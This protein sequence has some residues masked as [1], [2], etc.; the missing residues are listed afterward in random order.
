MACWSSHSIINLGLGT[1][2]RYHKLISS[3]S[4][5]L[6]N[7]WT[8]SSLGYTNSDLLPTLLLSLQLIIA[9][10]IELNDDHYVID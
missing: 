4:L 7:F 6:I 5:L 1:I 9:I 10:S 3:S 8:R 2:I